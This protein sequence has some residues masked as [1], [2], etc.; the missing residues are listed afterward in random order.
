MGATV[1]ESLLIDLVALS[2]Q[3]SLPRDVVM[4]ERKVAICEAKVA[5]LLAKGAIRLVT[6]G[7]LG[8]VC[9]FF[10]LKKPKTINEYRPISNMMPLYKFIRTP[11]AFCCNKIS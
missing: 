6:D 3:K 4:W 1:K 8:F 9:S 11:F 2:V 7:S 10:S 5:A